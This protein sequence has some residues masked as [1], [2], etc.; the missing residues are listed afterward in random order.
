MSVEKG[1][2]KPNADLTVSQRL[3]K[4]HRISAQ[5]SQVEVEKERKKQCLDMIQRTKDQYKQLFRSIFFQYAFT[6]QEMYS[7]FQ[8]FHNNFIPNYNIGQQELISIIE[9]M[10]QPQYLGKDNMQK[11]VFPIM[12]LVTN[13]ALD[14]IDFLNKDSYLKDY[15]FTSEEHQ[16]VFEVLNEGTRFVRFMKLLPFMMLFF[17]V[18]LN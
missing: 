14:Q 15:Q 9:V 11:K 7:M 8:E 1:E 17:I 12:G 10:A 6:E 18:H 5:L 2:A 3:D 13:N 4:L 16:Q